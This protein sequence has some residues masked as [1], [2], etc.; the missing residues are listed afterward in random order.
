VDGVVHLKRAE[1]EDLAHRL[2]SSVPWTLVVLASSLGSVLQQEVLAA[3][4]RGMATSPVVRMSSI[5]PFGTLAALAVLSS[6]LPGCGS[7]SPATSTVPPTKAQATAYAHAVNLRSG[8]LPG[9][10]VTE[11]EHEVAPE[12]S[13]A[14]QSCDGIANLAQPI[15]KVDSVSFAGVSGSEHEQISSNVE[16]MPT[17]RLAAQK[18]AAEQSARAISCAERLLLPKLS[19][20]NGSRVHFGHA[21]ITRL[22]D[23]L[24]GVPGA[25]GI[26]IAAPI[27]G[28]P[29]AIEPVQPTFYID[30]FAFLSGTA[31]V[32]LAATA[33]PNPTPKQTET[34]LLDLLHSRATQ[35]L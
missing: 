15:V 11:A 1:D 31:E 22:S 29:A 8:D 3:D 5:R 13:T 9:M 20:L 27:L 7:S 33:F 4:T 30:A 28:V 18:N 17:P 34:R 2:L 6:A 21:T 24:P 25:V 32:S 14:V 16:V 26:R 19:A 35:P 12:T 23:P 10:N